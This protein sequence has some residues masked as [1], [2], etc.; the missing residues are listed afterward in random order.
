MAMTWFSVGYQDAI[1]EFT[2]FDVSK[3]SETNYGEYM[4]GICAG[5]AFRRNLLD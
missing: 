4:R 2:G 5:L 3:L 1:D